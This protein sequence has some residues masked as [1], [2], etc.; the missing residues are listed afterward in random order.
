[1]ALPSRRYQEAIS[2]LAC[3]LAYPDPIDGLDQTILALEA[4]TISA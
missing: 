2:N 4:D 1:M 3:I